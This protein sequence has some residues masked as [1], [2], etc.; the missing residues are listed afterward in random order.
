MSVKPSCKNLSRG[1]I[2]CVDG[3]S[4]RANLLQAHSCHQGLKANASYILTHITTDIIR[5][6]VKQLS[7]AGMT[8]EQIAEI[9]GISVKTL[10]KYYRQE[11][12]LG[13]MLTVSELIPIS[14]QIAKDTTHKDSA[15]ER[16]FWLERKG[17]FV[18]TEKQDLIGDIKVTYLDREDEKA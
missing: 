4:H 15:S 10:T 7:A 11:C 3:L 16:R 17:G 8:Q 13:H 6:Q 1:V 14:L 18:R 9:I 5:E 12:D 2:R